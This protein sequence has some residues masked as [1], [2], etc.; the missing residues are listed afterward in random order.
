[1][2]GSIATAGLASETIRRG[3]RMY[4]DL[5]E[6]VFDTATEPVEGTANVFSGAAE[7]LRATDYA[8]ACP[9]AVVALEVANT[10]DILRQATADVF[11]NWIQAGTARFT[12]AGISPGRARELAILLIA[13]LEGAFIL[14]RAMRN[15]EALEV[16]AAAAAAAV[17]HAIAARP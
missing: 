11:D 13:A 5:V 17:E 2:R 4:Q 9:I 6:A 8:D 16:T 12:N 15:T 3:G 7:T 10:D 14:D 1:V